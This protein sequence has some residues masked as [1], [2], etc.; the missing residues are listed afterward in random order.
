MKSEEEDKIIRPG[1]EDESVQVTEELADFV[2]AY[3]PETMTKITVPDLPDDASGMSAEA[4]A[5]IPT[6]TEQV[7]PALAESA[8]DA[9]L[10]QALSP[11]QSPAAEV[12]SATATVA[13][14]ADALPALA[15]VDELQL[16]EVCAELQG[17]QDTPLA[18][19]SWLEQCQIRIGQLTE[20]IQKL[21]DRLDQLEEK[22]KV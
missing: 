14:D 11:E 7:T 10:A 13:A 20:E 1:H 3:K 18:A 8:P 6:L 21:N 19:D 16:T 4:L 5:K 15:E 12:G 9:S 17:A 2:P 22:T